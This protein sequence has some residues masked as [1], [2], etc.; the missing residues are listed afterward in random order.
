MS[1][2]WLFLLAAIAMFVVVVL[3]LYIRSPA[4]AVLEYRFEGLLW[5]VR[6]G[7]YWGPSCEDCLTQY[8]LRAMFQ[9]AE[10]VQFYELFCPVCL[11]PL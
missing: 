2:D 7:S 4:R 5:F 10:G 9:S 3:L 11:K 1:W 8:M 6:A